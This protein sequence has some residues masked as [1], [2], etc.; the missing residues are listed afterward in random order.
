MTMW[1]ILFRGRWVARRNKKSASKACIALD[2]WCILNAVLPPHLPQ[3]QRKPHVTGTGGMNDSI[4]IGRRS[5][6]RPVVDDPRYARADDHARSG[7]ATQAEFARW[8]DHQY[9]SGR[10]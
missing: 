1:P 10:R 3:R 4:C 7:N 8:L 5:S 2:T 9:G 6:V